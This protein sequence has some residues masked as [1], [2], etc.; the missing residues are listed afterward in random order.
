MFGHNE[1]TPV[2]Y[3]KLTNG[4]TNYLTV[5][6]YILKTLNWY[7]GLVSQNAEN[8]RIIVGNGGLSTSGGDTYYP[9][10]RRNF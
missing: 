8:I 5:E 1:C 9:N 10:V 2:V 7:G 6:N 3:S 4:I